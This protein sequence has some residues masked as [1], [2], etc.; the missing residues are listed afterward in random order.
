[1]K[2]LQLTVLG[3]TL[4]AGVIILVFLLNAEL[5]G[6][7]MVGSDPKHSIMSPVDVLSFAVEIIGR[8]MFVSVVGA[9]LMMR[10][11][12]MS[13]TQNRAVAASDS[14]TQYDGAM[15]QMQTV[16]HS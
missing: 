4:L 12:L 10:L 15:E 2:T 7:R 6:V 16:V 14:A 11:N 13:W 9:E 1:M 3:I 5:G 8:S